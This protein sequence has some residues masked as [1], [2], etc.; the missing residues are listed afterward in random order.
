MTGLFGTD[1][2]RIATG[3]V[4]LGLLAVP[5]YWPDGDRAT[6][7]PREQYEMIAFNLVRHGAFHPSPRL[8]ELRAAGGPAPYVRREPGYPFYLA[9]IYATVPGIR[10]LS[11]ACF[12][13]PGCEAAAPARRRVQQLSVL[14]GGV[15]VGAT[16]AATRVLTGSVVLAAGTGLL[17]L[18]LLPG[19]V[20][21]LLAAFLLLSHAVLA[22][23]TWRR[24]RIV[25]AVASGAALGL[26]ALTLA[27]FQYWLAGVALVWLAGLRQAPGRR[28]ALL[29]ACA[30][31]TLTAWGLTAPWMVRNAVQAGE[32]GISGRDGEVLAIRAEYGRMTWA[33]V[34]GALAYYIPFEGGVR[35]LAMRWL[36]PEPFG[37]AR[38]DRNNP[39][40]MYR[41]AKNR[42]GAVAARAER[43]EP[44]WRQRGA[45]AAESA[46]GRAAMQLM[47]ED[48]LKHAALTL[49]FA[50]RGSEVWRTSARRRKFGEIEH[51][52][53]YVRRWAERLSPLLLPGLGLML[54]L[55]WRRRDV[56]LAFLLLPA[57]YGFGVHALAT[58]FIA[59]YS[60]PLVPVLVVALALAVREG[61][62][63]LA[64]RARERPA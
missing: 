64:A 47:R 16:F 31:M 17:Y 33:E 63:L 61:G 26:L 51:D 35:S 10:S 57:A 56:G 15:T 25:T 36:E 12:S 48:W 1:G 29:P 46:Q 8:P 2:G 30:A 20:H 22:A 27:V 59:R 45:V 7:G 50:E 5:L 13:D 28:S 11:G 60:Y 40:G 32:F 43:L 37:Y 9:A 4:L 19:N 41:R 54:A 62:R 55:A 44:G 49:A 52:V 34:R 21:G 14:L 38:F 42:N 18:M 24:P 3:G 53:R 39:A 58:H 6:M 23:E